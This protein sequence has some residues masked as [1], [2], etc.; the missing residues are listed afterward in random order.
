MHGLR[1]RPTEERRGLVL[2]CVK[3]LRTGDGPG[4]TVEVGDC[5]FVLT[6][7]DLVELFLLAST[8]RGATERERVAVKDQL[9]RI[10]H[11]TEKP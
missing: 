3:N 5:S 1:A 11:G 4:E 9:L 10:I 6:D 8:W 2:Q 7:G